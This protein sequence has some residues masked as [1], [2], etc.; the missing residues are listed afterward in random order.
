MR[1]A[2]IVILVISI[3]GFLAISGKRT[4]NDI[5]FDRECG[6]YLKQAT[7]ANTVERAREP[8]SKVIK[9]LEKHDPILYNQLN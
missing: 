2:S 6:G 4:Y 3:V 5:I 9:Y 7:D 1:V 8:M